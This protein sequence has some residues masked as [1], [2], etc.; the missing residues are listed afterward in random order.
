MLV[1]EDTKADRRSQRKTK[2]HI[3]T[4]EP[5][6]NVTSE[7][8]LNLLNGLHDRMELTKPMNLNQDQFGKEKT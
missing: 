4:K 8:C 7:N 2:T 6:G 5:R 3:R 1:D